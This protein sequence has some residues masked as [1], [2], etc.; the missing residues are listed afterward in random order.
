MV[1]PS[2]ARFSDAPA[3][4]RRA[5]AAIG[6]VI[7]LAHVLVGI[8]LIRAFGGVRALVAAAGLTPAVTA[9]VIP[10]PPL[11]SPATG[12]KAQQGASGA[13]GKR[14]TADQIVAPPA[15]L[16]VQAPPAAPVAGTGSDTQS[17]A[18]ASGEGTGGAGSG[19]SP[20]SGG[21]GDGSG[22]RFVAA[23]PVKIAGDLAETDYPAAGRARR[24]GTAVIVVLT[25][26][27]DGHVTACRVHQPS[28]DPEADT[29]TCKLALE[30]F[31]FRPALDQH[32]DPIEATFG[33]Q[34]RFFWK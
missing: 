4:S 12:R 32:G 6:A 29:V 24:L 11:P 23:K 27:T 14:A 15:R 2:S 25:V 17:G 20:G 33:W 9:T 34:Q 3:L 7:V 13:A 18:S 28:G 5:R 30:R 21:S 16:P 22:G 8:G 26:G 31:R 19:N 10:A 1:R